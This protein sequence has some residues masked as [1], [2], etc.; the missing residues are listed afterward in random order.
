MVA[1][2]H[3]A[4]AAAACIGAAAADEELILNTSPLAIFTICSNNYVPMAKV[5]LSSA[6]THHPDASLYL[7]LAD[8]VLD[9]VGFYP[10]GCTII[11]ADTLG[12]PDF[13][14]FAF[15]Y[16]VMEFNTALK[17]FMIRKL[18][19]FGHDA[20][21]YFDPDIEIFRP[22]TSITNVLQAGASFV[23][24]P[25]ICQPSEGVPFPDDIGFMQAGIY[26]LGFLGV[27]AQQETDQILRWWSRRLE[28]QCINDQA[29]G[30]FV[31]QKFMDLVPAF[32]ARAV[33]LRDTAMNVAYWNLS[34]R[35]LTLDHSGTWSV[36]GAPLGFFHFS[37][38]NPR[39][40]SRL[41]K[42]TAGCAGAEIGPALQQIMTRYAGLLLAH[43]YGTIPAAIYA[44]G[45][46]R[47]GTNI[48]NFVRRLFRVDHSQWA[49]DP[50]ETFEEYLDFPLT[51]PW[52]G[53]AGQYVTRLMG[54]LH[55]LHPWFRQTFDPADTVAAQK[56]MNWLA[57]HG[58]SVVEDARLLEPALER[59]GNDA[60]SSRAV[61]AKHDAA[62]AD[63]NVIGYLNLA[64][65][66][67]EAGRLTLKAL[68]KTGLAAKGLA[69]SFNTL[70]SKIE[71][72]CEELLVQVSK[73][74][75]QIFVVNSDQ[76][77]LVIDHLN[78]RLRDDAYRILV[79]FW[80]LSNFP[81]AWLDAYRHVDEVWAPTRFIQRALLAKIEK[82]IVRMPLMLD[83]EPPPPTPR[84]RLNIPKDKFLFFFAFDYLSFVE[85]KN[86]QKVVESFKRAF[87][88]A[89]ATYP[90][91][92]V[93]KTLNAD[94]A[95]A[96]AQLLHDLLED[97]PDMILIERTL[98]REETLGL[99]GACDAVVSLHRSE[100]LGLLVAEAMVLGKP[101]ISTDYS[102]TT[103]LVTPRTG[104]PVDYRLIPVKGDEYTF[105]EGQVWADAD[106]DH[107]AWQMRQVFRGGEAVAGR[108]VAARQHIQTSYG[109]SEVT[110]RQLER[111][112]M[113]GLTA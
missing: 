42:H 45:R 110:R 21:L 60:R 22:L 52:Q 12:I 62:D 95:P 102:A 107:A 104:Y 61:P 25:H 20:V 13:L 98:S 6:Q 29:S 33:V 72:S 32:A 100:G 97:D 96:R 82:P 5:L 103:E 23:L 59:L 71:S 101:V 86:P 92:L 3:F 75:V 49:G 83:F 79:P 26:N 108:V 90:T 31:D 28:H 44:Y 78:D 43:G 10:D 51:E 11:P 18:L 37:G 76:I 113:L 74:P 46:F 53:S 16:D 70:S 48:P 87:R 109:Q 77:A 67:G 111:L 80:E 40:L 85:R 15:R 94:K 17:P 4:D 68:S 93:L 81:D 55:D 112:C 7:C 1:A 9:E 69:T 105:A 39:D 63:V 38:F 91:A 66:V 47:S 65:G 88:R 54:H 64:L 2:R 50:F 57:R 14:S 24:T 34:Q 99:I 58:D 84:S 89:G 8:T 35:Q 19:S 30:I 56:Y 27:G 73:A 41:S 36:D 106:V